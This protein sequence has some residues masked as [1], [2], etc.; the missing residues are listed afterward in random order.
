MAKFIYNNAKNASTGHMSF[1]LNCEYHPQVFYEE[2]VNSRSKWKLEDELLKKLWELITICR[3]N[4]HHAQ[5]LQKQA[6]NKSTK[7]KSYAL[8]DKVWLNNKYLK[9]K[10]NQKLEAKFFELFWVL[11]LVVK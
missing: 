1:N 6:Q 11:Y 3:K 8:S 7:P 4:L 2:I 9:T 10:R 5:E